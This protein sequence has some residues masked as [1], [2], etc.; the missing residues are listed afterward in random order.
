MVTKGV[1]RPLDKEKDSTVA[2]A[3]INII[4]ASAL[5]FPEELAAIPRVTAQHT[6]DNK[7]TLPGS[8]H[9]VC[10]VCGRQQRFC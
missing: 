6:K 3:S 2:L 1:A 9:G 7:Q 4:L 10:V 5:P 8:G